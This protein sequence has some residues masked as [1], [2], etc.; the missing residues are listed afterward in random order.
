MASPNFFST[1]QSR[2]GRHGWFEAYIKVVHVNTS[3]DGR[4]VSISG[5]FG[6]FADRERRLESSTQHFLEIPASGVQPPPPGVTYSEGMYLKGRITPTGPNTFKGSHCEPTSLTKE[7][8][9]PGNSGLPVVVSAS[10]LECAISVAKNKQRQTT[11]P[12]KPSPRS[13][14]AEATRPSGPRERLKT[15]DDVPHN[16]RSCFECYK[17]GHNRCVNT[18]AKS[19]KAREAHSKWA[20][21][22]AIVKSEKGGRP[23]SNASRQPSGPP[24]SGS[25]AGGN[26]ARTKPNDC[27]DIAAARRAAE[28]KEGAGKLEKEGDEEEEGGAGSG[29][30]TGGSGREE[31]A[32]RE[33][34]KK[35]TEEKRCSLPLRSG[36]ETE[37]SPAKKVYVSVGDF[38]PPE[39]D[40]CD[41]SAAVT[42]VATNVNDQD[43]SPIVVGAGVTGTEEA[44][45]AVPHEENGEDEKKEG[46]GEKVMKEMEAPKSPT[47]LCDTVAL[48]NF[49]GEDAI[50][51]N[52]GGGQTA[53]VMSQDVVEVLTGDE[54]AKKDFTTLSGM[55]TTGTRCDADVTMDGKTPPKVT[56]IRIRSDS[57]GTGP[58]MEETSEQ[59]VPAEG[60][61]GTAAAEGEWAVGDAVCAFFPDD[62]GYYEAVVTASQFEYE[63]NLYLMVRF[64]GYGNEE[65]VGLDGVY[66]SRGPEAVADQEALCKQPEPTQGTM[67]GGSQ[68]KEGAVVRPDLSPSDELA[69]PQESLPE[70][71]QTPLEHDTAGQDQV[72]QKRGAEDDVILAGST[73][74]SDGV[75]LDKSVVDFNPEVADT[76]AR[77]EE[78]VI[79]DRITRLSSVYSCNQMVIQCPA[80]ETKTDKAVPKSNSAG[81]EDP[82]G[83]RRP[84]ATLLSDL[85]N[86][87]NNEMAKAVEKADAAA[88]AAATGPVGIL[89]SIAE[90]E[91][92]EET[93]ATATPPPPPQDGVVVADLIDCAISELPTPQADHKTKSVG[94]LF[95]QFAEKARDGQMITSDQKMEWIKAILQL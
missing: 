90:A 8:F 36:D 29:R 84:A 73:L 48:V 66:P 6:S 71:E 88:F 39:G 94:E 17:K 57:T 51:F 55:L 1:L 25:A 3:P 47:K 68:V 50:K 9:P 56:K 28:S 79:R 64:V 33:V 49:V 27:L 80:P 72:S 77:D 38:T 89:P 52:I 61:S 87:S 92:E 45:P 70:A 44:P 91:V 86:N 54:A 16:E 60:D 85:N 12:A 24:S 65:Y 26:W 34:E 32:G 11:N 43:K 37:V 62:E 5:I 13:P 10:T 30:P 4:L 15:R 41:S 19:Q 67:A 59:Q 2:G 18:C 83:R 58:I 21:V 69:L 23:P 78:E 31:G 40:S 20:E 46:E 75:H 95:L 82:T 14:P 76:E 7:N 93:A 53:L 81:N 22:S 74:H 42:V 35:G 63:G